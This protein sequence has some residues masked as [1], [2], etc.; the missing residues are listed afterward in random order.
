[1]SVLN[2]FYF[3]MTIQRKLYDCYNTKYEG[4]GVE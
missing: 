3:I 1:M 4:I 2:A